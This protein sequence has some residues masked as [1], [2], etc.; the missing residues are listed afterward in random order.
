MRLKLG[1]AV[2]T[3]RQIQR[4]V[5]VRLTVVALFRVKVLTTTVPI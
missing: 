3:S 1:A 5:T 4:L 2:G